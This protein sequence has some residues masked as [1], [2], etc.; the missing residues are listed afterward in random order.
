MLYG[1]GFVLWLA[2]STPLHI[3]CGSGQVVCAEFL[4][5]NGASIRSVN[6]AGQTCLDVAEDAGQ[7]EMVAW[8]EKRLKD[9]FT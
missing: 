9:G 8:L 7:G 2:G 4:C 3:A 1:L 6:A 5:Q